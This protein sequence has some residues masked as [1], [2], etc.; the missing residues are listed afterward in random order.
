MALARPL[1]GREDRRMTT[2]LVQS[3]PTASGPL[4]LVLFSGTDDKLSAAAIL[5][6]GAAMMGRPV[7]LFLQYWAADAFRR[8]HILRHH[9]IAGG[10]TATQR[11]AFTASAARGQHWSDTLRQAKELGD[12]RVSVCALALDLLNATKDDFDPVVDDVEG[13]VAFMAEAGDAITFI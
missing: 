7:R 2:D 9:G 6:A 13:V 8:D 3:P 11:A 10:T 12:V 4:S 1:A 5:V